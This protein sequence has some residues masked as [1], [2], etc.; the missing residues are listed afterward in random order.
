MKDLYINEVNT[1]PDVILMETEVFHPF[2]CEEFLPFHKG[3]V[4]VV[5]FSGVES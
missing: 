2:C 3:V 1:F 5:T 4:S